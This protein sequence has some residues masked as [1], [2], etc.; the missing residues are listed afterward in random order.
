M[1]NI[2]IRINDISDI[3]TSKISVYDLNNRYVDSRGNM[4]GLKYNK[5]LRKMEIIK[6]VRTH[7]KNAGSYEHQIIMKKRGMGETLLYGNNMQANRASDQVESPE[8]FFNPDAFIETAMELA[9]T[10]KDRVKG[11]IMNIRNSNIIPKENKMESNQLE[12][13]FRNLDIDAIQGVENLVNYQKELVNYP[14][15]ITFYQ[16]KSDDRGRHIIETLASSNKKV[17]RFIYLSEMLENIRILYK[18]MDKIIKNLKSFLDASNTEDV[19]WI[20]PYEKQSFKDGM[21]SISTT[22]Q[23]ISNL[24]DDLKQLEDYTFNL[25]HFA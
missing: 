2:I 9:H 6:I 10:H 15:S 8:S 7:E 4:Y 20:T 12:D 24:L 21:V 1:K 22:I 17:N 25:D 23:E 13:I 16:A 5:A 19:K 3:D 18:N 11:I 14:R